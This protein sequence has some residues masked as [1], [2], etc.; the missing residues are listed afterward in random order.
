MPFP[1][2]S[3]WSHIL[4]LEILHFN[5]I[6]IINFQSSEEEIDEMTKKEDERIEMEMN[7]LIIDYKAALNKPPS[8]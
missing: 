3:F 1:T 6:V 7:K 2:P 8:K 5:S 4:L